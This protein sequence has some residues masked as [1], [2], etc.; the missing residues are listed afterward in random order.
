MVRDERSGLGFGHSTR[1]LD[2][3][4]NTSLSNRQKMRLRF[5]D[6]LNQEKKRKLQ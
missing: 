2:N 4:S 3:A 1:S 6:I 5:D